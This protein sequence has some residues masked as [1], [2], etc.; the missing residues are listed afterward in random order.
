MMVRFHRTTKPEYRELESTGGDL[1][2]Y[3]NLSSLTSPTRRSV[4]IPTR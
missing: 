4:P 2:T 1:V 3:A